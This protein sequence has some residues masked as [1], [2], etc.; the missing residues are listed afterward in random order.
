MKVS[1][2]V[3]AFLA[4][5]GIKH[6]FVLTGGAA[7][8]IIDSIAKNPDIDYICTQ[9]EQA[10]A[11]AADGYSRVTGNLGAAVATS[12]PG[13]TNLL[14]GVACSYCDSI[15]TIY[16]TGQVVTS[17]IRRNSGVRQMGFQEA[18]TVDIY[19]P[20]TKYAV[21]IEDKNRI[22]YELGKAVYLA[23]NGRPGPVVVDIPDDIQRDYIEPDELELFSPAAENKPHYELSDYQLEMYVKLIRESER[24]VIILGWGVVLAKAEREAKEFIEELGFPVLPTWATL[25]M[26]PSSHP[27][28][29]GP[30]GQHGTRYGNYTVQNADLV[31]LIGTR[32]DTHATGSNISSFARGAKKVVVDIDYCELSK[33]GALGLDIDLAL[34]TDAKAFLYLMRNAVV[35][36]RDISEWW[37]KIRKWKD[38]YPICPR[39][40]YQEE[41]VNPYVFT[42]AL[43]EHSVEGSVFFV[44]TGNALAWTMQAFEFKEGQRL[45]SAFNNTPMGYSLPASIGACFAL[46][47]RPVTC[48]AGDGGLQ[49]NIQELATIAKHNLPVKIFLINN[50]GYS[51]IRQ[52]QEQW[53]DS[54]Y[55]ASTPES[56]LPTPD[57]P[58]I[59]EAYGI[60]ACSITSNK[61]VHQ[62]I[63]DTLN[64]TGPAFCN[65]EINPSYR[66]IPQVKFGRPIEDGTPYLDRKEF[67][68]NMIVDPMEVSLE[69]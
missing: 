66:L 11:M 42:K 8:H 9:H 67:L 27:L 68:E 23:R 26:F 41:E 13:A 17:R 19:R 4:R 63:R 7:A 31:I 61:E 39:Q 40:Y 35:R 44:D 14:T 51:M 45:F 36:H 54:R 55:E 21:L 20:I 5:Q 47:K 57:F 46:G 24:P 34:R 2:Y 50:R 10:A 59:A 15:P 37:E 49:I 62:K 58:R 25:S 52:T 53:F 33:Y 18:P 32:L 6:A 48:I 69:D 30:F 38:R 16:I 28:I 60:E 1:D 12:G 64:T 22:G 3:A 56:G 43:A 29:V 65:V